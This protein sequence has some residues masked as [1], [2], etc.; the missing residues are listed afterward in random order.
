VARPFARTWPL[1]LLPPPLQLPVGK[2]SLVWH[3][4]THASPAQAWLRDRIVEVARGSTPRARAVS[5]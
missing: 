3:E 2:V 1:Q 4:S 5:G